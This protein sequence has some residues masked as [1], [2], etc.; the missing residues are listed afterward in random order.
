M[1]KQE[2]NEALRSDRPDEAPTP[3]TRDLL[4]RQLDEAGAVGLD[5]SPGDELC[6][7]SAELIRSLERRLDAARAA[8]AARTSL[9]GDKK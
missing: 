4:L 8:L 9:T 1:D 7:Q 2:M 3:E 5:L 6:R